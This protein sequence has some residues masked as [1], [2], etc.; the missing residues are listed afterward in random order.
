MSG[1]VRV[2]GC[3]KAHQAVAFAGKH[4][5]RYFRDQVV[6]VSFAGTVLIFTG[7]MASSDRWKVYDHSR[8]RR[9]LTHQ[10]K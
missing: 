4:N 3:A 9:W 10:L 2:M 7:L 8:F 1:T 5:V 6:L